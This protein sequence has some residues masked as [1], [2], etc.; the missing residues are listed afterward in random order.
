MD[1]IRSWSLCQFK[2]L[3]D[4][5]RIIEGIATTPS[6]D[7]M[8]DIV[9]PKGAQFKL[10]LSLLSQHDHHS[11]VGEVFEAKVTRDGIRVKARIVKDSGLDYVETAWKQIKAGLV[12]GLSIGFR[13]LKAEPIDGDKPWGA[14]RFKEWEWFELSAVTIPANAEATIT[15]LKQYDAAPPA[16]SLVAVSGQSTDSE[17]VVREAKAAILR[18]NQTLRLKP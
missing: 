9:E 17:R 18:A 11:P 8:G 3:D 14:L 12:R 6:T 13:P 10:P 5:Q 2:S 15:S 1:S 16:R 7:R 4:D